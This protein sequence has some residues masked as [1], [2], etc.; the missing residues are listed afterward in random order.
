MAKGSVRKKARS[1]TTAFTLKMKA[2]DR[3]SESSQERKARAK[4][5][6][7]Y[8]KQWKTTRQRNS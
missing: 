3:Y 6:L 8:V 1:G 4:P 2:A 7:C 5:K